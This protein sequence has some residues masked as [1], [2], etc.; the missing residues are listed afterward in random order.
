MEEKSVAE[1]KKLKG[2]T[3]K[4]RSKS[5]AKRMGIKS[6]IITDEGIAINSFIETIGKNGKKIPNVEVFA[7]ADGECVHKSNYKALKRAEISSDVIQVYT[8]DD[9]TQLF[10]PAKRLGADY[11][12]IKDELEEKFFGEKFP[13]DNLHVQIAYNV[14]DIKKHI[15]QFVN[16]II[17]TFF[18]INRTT[19]D[20]ESF[21]DLIGTTFAFRPYS[22]LDFSKVKNHDELDK[23]LDGVSFYDAYFPGVF[24]IPEKKKNEQVTDE[25]REK[26]KEHNYNVLRLLSLV[27]Q[28]C[29]HEDLKN[30]SSD[31]MLYDLKGGLRENNKE[32]L[33]FLDELYQKVPANF[34]KGFEKNSVNNL[35]M[36]SKIYPNVTFDDLVKKYYFYVAIKSQNNIGVNLR[37]V[38]DIIIEKHITKLKDKSY[39]TA[40]SKLYTLLGFVLFE[41]VKDNE[42]VTSTVKKLRKN[43]T[44]EGRLQ[45]YAGFA[46]AAWDLYNKQLENTVQVFSEELKNK[47]KSELAKSL[48][49][50]GKDYALGKQN[51]SYFSKQM[52]LLTKFLDAK[53]INIL[54]TGLISRFDNI[55]D[56]ID[57][58]SE[59]GV[60]VS[61]KEIYS[62]FNDARA[63]SNE[64]RIIKNVARMKDEDLT[65][66]NCMLID[67]ANFLG[68]EQPIL[69]WCECTTDEQRAVNK[70]FLARVQPTAK[71]GEKINHQLRNFIINNVVKSRWFF[72]LARYTKPSVCREIMKN[73]RLIQFVLKEIPDMQIVRYYK[74]VSGNEPSDISIAR[75]YLLERLCKFTVDKLFSK[76]ESLTVQENR[77][78]DDMSKKQKSRALV[79]LYLTVAY[80]AIKGVMSVNTVFSIAFSCLERDLTLKQGLKKEGLLSF[81]GYYIE[82]DG[83][84]VREYNQIRDK[85]RD[86]V[87]LSKEEKRREYAQLTP[88]LRAMHYDLHSYY[89]VHNNYEEARAIIRNIGDKQISL[90]KRYRDLIAHL[91]VAAM[92]N[93][94]LGEMQTITSYYSVY[95]YSL[96]RILIDEQLKHVN[97]FNDALSQF[98]LKCSSRIQKRGAYDRDMLWV[99]NAPFAYNLA[100]YKNLSIEDLFYGRPTSQGL[101]NAG[102]EKKSVMVKEVYPKEYQVG[103]IVIMS[104]VQ[105]TV[106]GGLRGYIQGSEIKVTVSPKA[107]KNKNVSVS[108]NSSVKVVITRWDANA[109]A[110]NAELY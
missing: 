49:V 66:K 81:T 101:E 64:L 5:K 24:K 17:Y 95:V 56:L 3:G 36:L 88:I 74:S 73:E 23:L 34:N 33:D 28:A 65:V 70:A 89:C 105:R 98:I 96:E 75:D 9:M 2:A 8:T 77:S 53:E 16:Q 109:N 12:D 85:I 102:G 71:K 43:D 29:E 44:E 20:Y 55:A 41:S 69:Q 57:C 42:L 110:Y 13:A 90:S 68:L 106:R 7:S 100:R 59:C 22:E 35:Y 31:I 10:N 99:I 6:T 27:R 67:A 38:R 63:V 15:I 21:Q 39:D 52:L 79:R 78:I 72:Y 83:R 61:F 93:E 60:Q 104:D 26:C 58:A 82:K 86:D 87:S 51:V 107:V 48:S 103:N 14:L 54:L 32:L 91:N 92:M 46:D 19:I 11:I 94:Y 80:L 37:L 4:E 25:E 50:Q 97:K 18:N 47:F 62:L 30:G 40:R 1:L 45:I 76:V 108:E 84:L